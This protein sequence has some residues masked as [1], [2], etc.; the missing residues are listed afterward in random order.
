[1]SP[2]VS[3]VM[4]VYNGRRYLVEQLESV[5]AQ[6]DEA[7]E[8]IVV[9][10]ASADDSAALVRE[11]NSPR[12]RLFVN[13]RNMGVIG[14]FERALRLARHELVFLSDQDDIWLP[15]KKAAFVAEF[16]RDPKVSLVISDADVI[17]ENGKLLVKSFLTNVRGGFSGGVLA[18][19]WRNRYLGCAMAVRS[20]VLRIALPIPRR[21]PMHD[22]WLGILAAMS[23]RITYL[24]QSYLQYRRHGSNASPMGS[25][26]LRVI[27][28]RLSLLG[29]LVC[30][31]L[32]VLLR[33]H[34]NPS[35]S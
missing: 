5:L 29:P 28:W 21:V 34:R 20:S 1:M 10:D 7:D 13:S 6:L 22:M 15:G 19:L 14:T 11:L 26:W 23:G 18:T 33:T 27:S 32:A 31:G 3:V 25:S 30:R 4:A 9:D 2:P 35:A 12:I 17:D 8:L 24:P 16:T